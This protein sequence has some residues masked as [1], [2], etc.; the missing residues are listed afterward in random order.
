MFKYG[1]FIIFVVYRFF[2]Y[3]K[4]R[5]YWDLL[6]ERRFNISYY[7]LRFNV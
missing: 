2:C 7:L 4:F 6:C 1:W 5:F 3:S